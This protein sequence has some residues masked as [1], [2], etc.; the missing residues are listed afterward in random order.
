MSETA[1]TRAHRATKRVQLA[2]F[3]KSRR[4]RITPADVGL[5][6]GPR[7]RTPG[8]RR[9]EVAQLSGIGITW[10]TWLEQGRPINASV[11]VLDA[12]ARTLRLDPAERAHLYRLADMP[13][14]PTT[15]GTEVAI[16]PGVPLI[17]ERLDP[18]P[19]A[20]V[21]P[22]F[23][24]LAQNG[25]Y[26]KLFPG[27]TDNVLRR[28]FLTPDCCNPYARNADDLRRMVAYLRG[29]Y[30][31]HFDD[32]QWQHLVNELCARSRDFATLWASNDVA[33]PVSLIKQAR[34]PAIGSITL[35]LTNLALPLIDGAW[36]QIFTPVDE[37]QDARLATLLAMSDE[38]RDASWADHAAQWHVPAEGRS[39]HVVLS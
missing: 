31:K 7:R 1:G 16:P 9:E 13:T 2:E 10:Y 38:Q 17:L 25:S 6:P 12:I 27:F 3:L 23:D 28:V 24:V 21:S 32:P 33:V 37:E 35:H 14:V 22:K 39:A 20:L 5:L 11:Q 26:R 4:A 29:A 30:A 15:V 36:I 18:L 34:H 8:L 19:A